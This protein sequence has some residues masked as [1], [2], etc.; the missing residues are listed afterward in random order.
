MTAL[1]Q[2]DDNPHWGVAGHNVHTASW[3]P[4]PK[5]ADETDDA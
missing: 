2:W 3:A 1:I 4:D 5:H